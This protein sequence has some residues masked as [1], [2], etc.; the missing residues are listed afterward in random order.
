MSAERGASGIRKPYCGKMNDAQDGNDEQADDDGGN[1]NI[2]SVPAQPP[3]P[4]IV[5]VIIAVSG[6]RI[7]I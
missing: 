2:E 7:G 4:I 6:L 5:S 1:R 3:G